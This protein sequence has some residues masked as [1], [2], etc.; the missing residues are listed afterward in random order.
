MAR[1]A[2]KWLSVISLATLALAP[3]ASAATF[4]LIWADRIEVTTF[5][6]NV[7]FTLSGTDIALVVNK[8]LTDIEAPEFFGASFEAIS[9]NPLVN[10]HPFINNPGPSIMP[11]HP[12]EAIGS[13]S[14]LNGVLTSKLLPGETL[15]NTA[16]LQ[17]V[18][19]EV[20]YP[21]GFSGMVMFDLAITMGGNVAYYSIL[22]NFTLGSQFAISF[23]S[24]ARAS[25]SAVP[26][27]AKTT[28]WGAIKRLYR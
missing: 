1:R 19:L 24:A 13:V 16:G 18:S 20:Q 2:L 21:A 10:A 12:D 23:P 5:P 14:G 4:D 15:H 11:L 6:G 9:S 8:G 17:V 7:G 26:T 22:A 3:A 28:T 27:A 25:S